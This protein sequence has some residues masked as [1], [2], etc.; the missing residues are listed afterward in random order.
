MELLCL[1]Q[2][3]AAPTVSCLRL[4]LMTATLMSA[5][6]GCGEIEISGAGSKVALVL[7]PGLVGNRP[8]YA[9]QVPSPRTYCSQ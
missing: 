5:V 1:A 6:M 9:A 7:G 8:H 3:Q 2:Q 4:L